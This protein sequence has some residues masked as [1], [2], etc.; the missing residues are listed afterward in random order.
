[1]ADDKRVGVF[2][3][4]S[5]KIIKNWLKMRGKTEIV[6]SFKFETIT[7]FMVVGGLCDSFLSKVMVL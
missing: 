3:Q 7:L 2:D 5:S 4:F 1:M 6:R